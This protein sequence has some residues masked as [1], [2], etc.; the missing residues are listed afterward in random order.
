VVRDPQ[1]TVVIPT[2]NRADLL[3]EAVASARGEDL[4]VVV[5]DDGSDDRTPAWLSEQ[6]DPAVRWIRLDPPRER[7]AARNAGLEL[8]VTPHVLFL[9]DDDLLV[10]G[11]VEQL[12]ASLGR[13]PHAVAAAG[14]YV[15]FGSYAEGEVARRQMTAPVEVQR[16]VWRELLWGWNVQPGAGLWRTERLRALGG[17][18]EEVSFAEDFELNLRTYPHPVVVV[19]CTVSRYRHHGVR[20]T[21]AERDRQRAQDAAVRRA[22]VDG[23]PEHHRAE[24]DAILQAKPLFDAALDAYTAGDTAEAL[25]T[26]LRSH[27]LAPSLLA[28][29]ILGPWMVGLLGKAAVASL[30]PGDLRAHLGGAHRASRERRLGAVGTP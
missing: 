24:G 1:V 6:A 23:L 19:P 12:T 11:G 2:R 13:H 7:S 20:A 25:R 3:E 22:F 21:G 5:V 10:P 26:F 15:T 17:W 8:V 30:L 14:T 16:C 28:S 27:R 18:D 4:D 9:D 29:P